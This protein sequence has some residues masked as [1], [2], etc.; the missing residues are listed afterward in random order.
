MSPC[1]DGRAPDDDDRRDGA[2]MSPPTSIAIV[3]TRPALFPG[4][5]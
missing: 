4:A 5:P 1:V 2:R 3:P